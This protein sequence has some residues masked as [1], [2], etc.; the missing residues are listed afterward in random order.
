MGERFWYALQT[1]PHKEMQV[2]G[3]LR[4]HQFEVF[5]PTAKVKPVNPRAAKVRAYFPNYL[6]VNADLEAV[7]LSALQWVPGAIGL[8]RF[9]GEP[10]IIPDNFIY[11]LKRRIAEIRAAGGLHLDGLKPGD[12][13]KIT[14]G[15]FA[16]YEAI[17]DLRLSGSDRVQV[18]LEWLG[19]KLHVQVNADAIE[20]QRAH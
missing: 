1:K 3:Y 2:N 13:V 4:S 9:G 11:D 8:I 15:S 14:S 20:K 17:F 16:G 18:M 12:T 5:Y 6:F 7:G 10:A 19:R